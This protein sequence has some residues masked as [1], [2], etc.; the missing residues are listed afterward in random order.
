MANSFWIG[1]ELAAVVILVLVNGFFV[2][3]EFSIVAVR[4]TKLQEMVEA[5]VTGARAAQQV[6][7]RLNDALAA[8]Q[9]GITLASLALGWVGEPALAR[10]LAAGFRFL[11]GN[12]S[13][14][15]AHAI[16]ATIALAIITY[17]HMVI[18]EQ[19]PKVAALQVPDSMSRLLAPPLLVFMRVTRPALA[20][21][22]GTGNWVLRRLGMEPKAIEQMVHSVEELGLLI[23]QTREAGVLSAEQ[24]ELVQNVFE[25]TS[26]KVSEV[27][28]PRDRADALEMHMRQEQILEA[29]REGAHTRMPVYDKDVDNIVGIVNTKHLFHLLSLNALVVLDDAMYPALFVSP[30]EPIS[31]VLRRMKRQKRHMAIVR[32]AAGKTLGLVTLED[33]LEEIVG[34][35]EDEHDEWPS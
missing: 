33:I 19:V 34:E 24:A 10:L 30:D 25:L 31:N 6:T 1:L 4:R 14:F 18:G 15:A 5:G 9:L 26:K 3:A 13:T 16:S 23:E 17:L 32:D 28:I 7:D 11:P 21:M 20:V 35:I 2:A 29:V 12:W 8:A 27:M 22:N